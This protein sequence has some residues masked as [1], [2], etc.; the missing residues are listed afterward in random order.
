MFTPRAPTLQRTPALLHT[1]QALHPF[2]RLDHP[3]ANIRERLLLR[4][5]LGEAQNVVWSSELRRSLFKPPKYTE[6]RMHVVASG[7]K[8][9]YGI[10]DLGR[11]SS[12]RVW[13]TSACRGAVCVLKFANTPDSNKAKANL[14]R[15]CAAWHQAYPALAQ[16]VAV[17]MR[18]GRWALR[19]PHFSRVPVAERTDECIEAVRDVLT[20]AFQA[21]RLKHTDVAWRNIGRYKVSM[22]VVAIV[23]YDM[24]DVI[25]G[26]SG[27]VEGEI[28]KLR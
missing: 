7:N 1:N 18:S 23:V 5:E 28:A 25:E 10:E 17:E 2:F 15:E 6:G 4:F 21:N 8:Y 20:K 27:W 3:F 14:E 22:G 13:L 19:M 9:L 11:G 26:D 12:G 16:H 24:G